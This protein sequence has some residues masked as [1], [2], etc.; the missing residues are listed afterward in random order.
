MLARDKRNM[1]TFT[2]NA[3]W[4]ALVTVSAMNVLGRDNPGGV[5]AAAAPAAN[6]APAV[7][8]APNN[9]G[10]AIQFAEPI[11]DFG[12]IQAGELVKHTYTFTNN[13]D[14][15]LQ[16][17][18]V[19]PSCGC[20]TAGD[21]TRKVPPGAIGTVPV[22]FN[23]SHFNG[24]VFKTI[25]VTSNDRKRPVVV[26]QLKG[27]IWKPLETV[28][29]Y[30]VINVPPDA[31]SASASVR[32]INN[33]EQPITL[34]EPEGNNKSFSAKIIPV[35]PGKE[36]QL[37]IA[38]VGDLNVG[39]IQG[40]FLLKTSWTNNPM[41]EVPFWVNV[42]PALSVIPPHVLLPRGP[43]H[44]KAPTA[45]TI[46]NNSTNLMTLSDAA[47]NLPGVDVQIKEVQPGRIYRALLTF[48]DGFEIPLGQQALLSMKSSSARFPEIRVP[49]TQPAPRVIAASPRPA[50]TPPPLPLAPPQPATAVAKPAGSG[51]GS[52]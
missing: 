48:P 27:T 18:N 29:S 50:V 19:Q 28:P 37:A 6:P 43:L 31:T 32:I 5:A 17:N 30:T 23:S 10:P 13:G 51:P 12:R 39:N 2:R 38:S 49:I 16:V 44:T 33:T 47:V 34:S 14:Q 7:K 3:F 26:L 35:K 52:H 40:K 22:Q 15:P 42:Q 45:V 4:A 8:P 46:Q 21:W 9:A 25:T 20:T 36:F 1:H 24:A 11:Y 41:L